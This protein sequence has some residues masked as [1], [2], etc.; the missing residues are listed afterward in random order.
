MKGFSVSCLCTLV[1]LPTKTRTV[2]IVPTNV[3]NNKPKAEP[4]FQ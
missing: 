3:V 2:I 4:Y 1:P